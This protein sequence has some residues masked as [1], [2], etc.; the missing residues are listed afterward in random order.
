LR[1]TELPVRA[2]KRVTGIGYPRTLGMTKGDIVIKLSAASR[3]FFIVYP[4]VC[5][6][7]EVISTCVK[8]SKRK[9]Y[10]VV[11]CAVPAFIR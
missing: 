5:S 1:N 4:L 6:S 2:S 11:G 3:R 10:I 8:M 9:T 7:A